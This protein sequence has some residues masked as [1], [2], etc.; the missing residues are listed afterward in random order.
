MSKPSAFKRLW[1]AICRRWNGWTLVATLAAV[2][3]LGWALGTWSTCRGGACSFDPDLF[4]A[5]GTWVGGLGTIG[6]LIFAG[7]QLRADARREKQNA[8]ETWKQIKD[9]ASRV[10]LECHVGQWV[11]E[12]VAQI[13]YTVFNE[14]PEPAY[15]V[16]L[17]L[18]GQITVP[19]GL[20]KP[21]KDGRNPWANVLGKWKTMTSVGDPAEGWRMRDA[22]TLTFTM[23][24]KKWTQ[25]GNDLK[26]LKAVD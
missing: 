24:G 8:D 26:T 20:I 25:T 2:F 21:M 14:A 15:D 6:A 11:G 4:G 1:Q 18:G 19:L 22:S 16:S 7:R 23:H 12:Q 9:D 5:L 3:A 10:R 13:S 17:D